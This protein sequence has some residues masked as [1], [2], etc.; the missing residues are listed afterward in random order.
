MIPQDAQEEERFRRQHKRGHPS[1]GQ[2]GPPP[3][4]RKFRNDGMDRREE[5][6]FLSRC[7]ML[8]MELPAAVLGCLSTESVPDESRKDETS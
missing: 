7:A 2:K 3:G 8:G 4:F 6:Q 1:R 5:T